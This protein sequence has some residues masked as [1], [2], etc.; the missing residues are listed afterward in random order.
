MICGANLDKDL[1]KR[2]AV[3][4]FRR[5]IELYMVSD[6]FNPKEELNV[7]LLKGLHR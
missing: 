4:Q 1:D 2:P 7:D 6:K 3:Q 5:S